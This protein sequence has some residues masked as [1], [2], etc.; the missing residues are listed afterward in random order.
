M[1]LPYLAGSA[2]SAT[3]HVSTAA[4][5]TAINGFGAIFNDIQGM[6]V[7]DTVPP[8]TSDDYMALVVASGFG[9]ATQVDH[10][11]VDN[12]FDMQTRRQNKAVAS[13]ETIN[14]DHS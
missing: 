7:G 8:Q 9:L 10:L 2:L 14:I 11:R 5:D 1:Y 3:G 13:H 12:L 4:M 6:H